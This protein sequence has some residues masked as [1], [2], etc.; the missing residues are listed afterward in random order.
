V[1]GILSSA[2]W[3][4]TSSLSRCRLF[5]DSQPVISGSARPCLVRLRLRTLFSG[6]K[7][8]FT[9]TRTRSEIQ[10]TTCQPGPVQERF[11]TGFV[12]GRFVLIT[13]D[14]NSASKPQTATDARVRSDQGEEGKRTVRSRRM[15]LTM[16]AALGAW[17][18]RHGLGRHADGPGGGPHDVR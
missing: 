9:C 5:C 11:C 6:G 14:S 17:I 8:R 3:E 15:A 13:S 10:G 1:T 7:A 4:M 16:T 12:Q 18:S 2:T